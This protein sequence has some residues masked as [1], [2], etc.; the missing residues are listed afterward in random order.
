M[1]RRRVVPVESIFQWWLIDNHPD[2]WHEWV[3][4]PSPFC[5]LWDW[6]E[7]VHPD[8]L[9]EFKHLCEQEEANDQYCVVS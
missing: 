4:V 7:E 1:K 8:V 5:G 3:C 6:S 2:V 9:S